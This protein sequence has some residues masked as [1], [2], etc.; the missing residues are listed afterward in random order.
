MGDTVGLTQV[1]GVETRSGAV[2]EV[3]GVRTRERK[4]SMIHYRGSYNR[5]TCQLDCLS[6]ALDAVTPD[7]M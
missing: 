1:I 3:L 7:E 5:R 6:K 2:S 4:S